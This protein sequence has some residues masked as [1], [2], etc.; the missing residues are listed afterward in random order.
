VFVSLF[1]FPARRRTYTPAIVLAVTALIVGG[2]NTAK[3]IE[4]INAQEGIAA[5]SDIRDPSQLDQALKKNPSNTFLKLLA[6]ANELAQETGRATAKLSEEIEP[7]A[8]SDM[9]FNF[10]TATREELAAYRRDLKA[11]AQNVEQALPRFV[12]FLKKERSDVEDLSQ[13]LK[14]SDSMK[15]GFLGGVDERQARL[16]AFNSKMFAAR[17]EFYRALENYVTILIDQQGK[18]KVEPN[19]QFRF[20]DGTASDRFNSALNAVSIALKKINELDVERKELQKSDV[21]SWQRL[22]SAV[23]H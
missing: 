2:M 5:L 12:A 3:L 16:L 14:I 6:G 20:A 7:K 11:A 9:N 21:E 15:R 18:Y 4:S 1:G 17:S 19:G 23:M 22:R 10:A 8:L 13:S